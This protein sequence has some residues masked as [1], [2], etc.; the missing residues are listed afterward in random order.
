MSQNR[1]APAYQEYASTIL[2]KMEFRTMTLQERGLLYT[3]RLESWANGRFPSDAS[4]LAKI[5]GLPLEE[6][7]SVLLAVLVMPFFEVTDGLI[8]CP[9]LEEYRQHLVERNARQSKG[10]KRGAAMTN[11]KRK[12]DKNNESGD[13]SSTPPS[14]TQAPRRAPRRGEVESLVQHS[15]D[16][17]SKNQLTGVDLSTPAW[18]DDDSPVCTASEYAAAKGR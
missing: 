15:T 7:T 14:R 9:E 18:S 13:E 6:I 12:Q 17:N 8:T 1:D 10:G 3:L 2:S 4:S 11:K 5:L 16:Q